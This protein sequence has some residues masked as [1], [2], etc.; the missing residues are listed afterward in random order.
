MPSPTP[1]PLDAAS[2]LAAP[3]PVEPDPTESGQPASAP[4]LA[5]L[6]G[7]LALC[8]SRMGNG[9]LAELRRMD[10]SDP[11]GG[12]FWG[13]LFDLVEPAHNLDAA[14]GRDEQERRWA[15]ILRAMAHLPHQSGARLGDALAESGFSELRFVRLLRS[16]GPELADAVRQMVAFLASKGA[17]VDHADTAR[18]V[19]FQ[20]EPR[21]EEVRRDLA[22][23]YYAQLRRNQA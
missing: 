23:R 16:R 7:A 15:V 13:V 3:D 11:S 8:L 14:P 22:R 4:S 2:L 12:A 18:L 21:D 5:R 20:D 10:P 9:P 17:H 6:I 19:L 1:A